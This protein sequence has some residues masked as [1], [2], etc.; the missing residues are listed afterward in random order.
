MDTTRSLAFFLDELKNNPNRKFPGKS[1]EMLQR[2]AA[3][4]EDVATAPNFI[5]LETS[6]TV[7]R[8]GNA[9]AADLHQAGSV[10]LVN[11]EDPNVPR[12]LQ[13]NNVR[14]VLSYAG[15]LHACKPTSWKVDHGLPGIIFQDPTYTTENKRESILLEVSGQHPWCPPCSNLYCLY[16]ELSKWQ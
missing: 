1:K 4:P 15:F 9:N 11:L 3:G 12:D 16:F 7:L 2:A 5:F 14:W 6:T 8:G 10:T 13:R